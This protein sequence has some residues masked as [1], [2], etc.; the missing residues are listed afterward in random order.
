MARPGRSPRRSTRSD[1]AHGQK[2]T[3]DY[4]RSLRRVSSA[5]F[6]ARLAICAFAFYW[7]AC[8][9]FSCIKTILARGT[10]PAWQA[11]AREHVRP[12]RIDFPFKTPSAV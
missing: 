8:A 10:R 12:A 1:K 5:N 3:E 4:S 9:A 2:S 6:F 7:V 11:A